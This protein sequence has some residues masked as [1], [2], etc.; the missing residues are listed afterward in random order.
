MYVIDDSFIVTFAESMSTE[1]AIFGNQY[2]SYA[3]TGV[4]LGN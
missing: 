3:P 1:S 2:K 4:V